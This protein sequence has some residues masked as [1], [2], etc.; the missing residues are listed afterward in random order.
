MPY[1]YNP[2]Y[3]RLDYSNIGGSGGGN[4]DNITW[5]TISAS[6]ALVVGNGYFC[7]APGGAL[8]LPLPAVSALG[9]GIEIILNGATSFTITQGAGQSV[10]LG[11][12]ASTA[13]VGGSVS[14]TQQGDAIKLVCMT[15][16]LVW[17]VASSEGNFTII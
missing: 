11:N 13:G 4:I 7:V 16:N 9:D 2:L 17:V 1:A 12:V 14:S 3:G 5:N 8:S 10:R 15:A 6:Q